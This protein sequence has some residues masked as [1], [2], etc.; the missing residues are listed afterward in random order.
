MAW[1]KVNGI[2]VQIQEGASVDDYGG[3][4]TQAT[5]DMINF[6]DSWGDDET[7]SISRHGSNYTLLRLNGE[8]IVIMGP[9][10]KKPEKR[11]KKPARLGRPEIV[12]MPAFHT[13]DING[14]W[15]GLT[16]CL[17]GRW[18][19]PFR[20]VQCE[21][22]EVYPFEYG[23]WNFNINSEK[24]E[25]Y[26][27]NLYIYTIT[28]PYPVDNTF[29]DL[30]DVP[31]V[32]EYICA[33]TDSE[34]YN[35]YGGAEWTGGP[36]MENPECTTTFACGWYYRWANWTS[37]VMYDDHISIWVDHS[38]YETDQPRIAT[39]TYRQDEAGPVQEEIVSGAVSAPDPDD[40]ACI[41]H[42]AA[43]GE[44][45]G[46]VN[47]AE[48]L[49]SVSPGGT[50]IWYDVNRI[51]SGETLICKGW[52]TFIGDTK[53][54][55]VYF[56]GKNTVAIDLQYWRKYT[57]TC[58]SYILDSQGATEADT[59]HSQDYITVYGETYE[60]ESHADSYPS[61]ER[62][63]KTAHPRLYEV[64]YE[65]PL[66]LAS[67]CRNDEARWEYFCFNDELKQYGDQDTL[68]DCVDGEEIHIIPYKVGDQQL[69][70]NGEFSLV[71]LALTE[72]TDPP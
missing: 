40:N 13:V 62:R 16:I 23:Q 67:L 14:D 38:K 66:V 31:A 41:I 33:D 17:A 1:I 10:E 5:S 70:G 44:A 37:G 28:S 45:L 3:R 54:D 59:S 51:Y 72:L 52:G 9:V 43:M 57:W 61:A 71:G 2:R 11:K 27:D 55:G 12:Y 18:G 65:K 69:Y 24:P 48:K 58:S 26:E 34:Q 64:G 39:V 6:R 4:I 15:L 8:D 32:H 20:F 49:A 46:T 68:Y 7:Y 35:F 63:I 30:F 22:D 25:D 56:H 60:L 42:K 53:E 50:A 47:M 19:P 36:V 21:E 29:E